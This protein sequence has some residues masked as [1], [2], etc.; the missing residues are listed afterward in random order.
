MSYLT[1]PYMVSPSSASWMDDSDLKA[2]WKFS[3]ASGNV[4]NSSQSSES[5]G[6]DADLIM[7]GGT[8]EQTAVGTL[9][10]VLL[11]G[12]DD[13]C[14]SGTSLSQFNFLHEGQSTMCFW[15]KLVSSYN[16]GIIFNNNDWTPDAGT[17]L[18][19]TRNASCGTACGTMQQPINNGAPLEANSVIVDMQ[20]GGSNFGYIPDITD[21]YFYTIRVDVDLTTDTG[22]YDRDEAGSAESKHNRINAPDTGVDSPSPFTIARQS[23][24]SQYF[25]NIL[26]SE[27]SFWNRILTDTEVNGLWNSGSGR[28]IYE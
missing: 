7:T 18:L 9:K 27:F 6:T 17:L 2:Y 1:N 22:I 23:N 14:V 16:Y 24:A 12:V 26:I 19:T 10:A 8:Y 25:A 3:Q 28:A 15:M 13:F 4:E 11:D 20:A 21:Y 5:L